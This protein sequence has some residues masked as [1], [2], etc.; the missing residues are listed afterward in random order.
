MAKVAIVIGD[1]LHNTYGLIR[2]LGEGC[3]DF[4]F[5]CLT[6]T[7]W[8]PIQ[9]SKYIKSGR[10][11]RFTSMEELPVLLENLKTLPGEKYL[12]CSSDPIAT[13]VDNHEKQLSKNFITPC[14]GNRIGELFNKNDQCKLAA[15][16]GL[17]V[18]QS[19][20][21]T[22]G[23]MTDF[24][25]LSYPVF[26]KPL[27]S[28]EGNKADIHICRSECEL[29][30]M[31]E[32]S[33]NTTSFIIQEFIEDGYDVNCVGFRTEKQTMLAC[34]IR[35]YRTYPEKYGAGSYMQVDN[36]DQYNI[37][38]K[39]IERFLEKAGYYGPFSAEF[40]HTDT[41]NY[42]MEVNFRNDG[43]AYAVTC[44]GL[45]YYSV[46]FRGET[47]DPLNFNPVVVMNIAFD[48]ALQRTSKNMP[49]IQWLKQF[50]T[51]DGYLDFTFKDPMPVLWRPIGFILR[52]LKIKQA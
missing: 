34:V 20:V 23:E 38:V 12:I 45:N 6:G 52:R 47:I 22:K 1:S 42:F 9:R 33:I 24:S 16:C 18:P 2:S 25:Q 10:F 41:K 40:I 30:S 21:Y 32:A 35:K 28:S 36:I 14:R 15:E 31:L 13:W 19:I 7:D 4:Y 27:V 49:F 3:V 26:I 43:L 46:Y 44:A 39:G 50:A 11:I 37:N 48:R 29:R 5:L 51:A 8:D 17:D